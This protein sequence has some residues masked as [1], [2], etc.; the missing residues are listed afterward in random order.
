MNLLGAFH[1]YQSIAWKSFMMFGK[2]LILQCLI[3]KKDT[4]EKRE[5]N[6]VWLAKFQHY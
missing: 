2:S 5:K 3:T 6:I 4:G 1:F